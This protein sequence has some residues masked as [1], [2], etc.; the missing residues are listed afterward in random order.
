M[1]AK[2]KPNPNPTDPL[3]LNDTFN[4]YYGWVTGLRSGKAKTLAY[5][6]GAVSLALVTVS[7]VLYYMQVV[8]S[9]VPALIGSPAG[10]ALFLI[11]Y[12]LVARTRASEWKLFRWRERYSFRQRLKR[13][14]GLFLVCALIFIPLGGYIPY[15]IGGSILIMLML[16]A[17]ATLRRTQQEMELSL[18]GL[19]DPRDLNEETDDYAEPETTG[20]DT[21]IYD[22]NDG[23]ISGRLD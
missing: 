1:A 9:W 3:M 6:W 20:T 17:I 13:V 16:T 15:G 2:N 23:T 7:S 4:R 18:Q 10:V 19:P 8:G 22:E 21:V 14:G 12:G 5:G 11:G